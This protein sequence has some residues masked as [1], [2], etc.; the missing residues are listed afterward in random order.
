MAASAARSTLQAN[1]AAPAMPP[2]PL[3]D[4]SA[5]ATDFVAFLE[6]LTAFHSA[7]AAGVSAQQPPR[8]DELLTR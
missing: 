7:P 8:V 5:I 1:A 3:P 2:G 4:A 6:L